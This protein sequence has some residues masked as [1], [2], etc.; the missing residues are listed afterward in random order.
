V[1]EKVRLLNW[2]S[3]YFIP[4]I[5]VW[6]CLPRAVPSHSLATQGMTGKRIGQFCPTVLSRSLIKRTQIMKNTIILG[7]ALL[8]T[9]AH[10]VIVTF[11]DL[12]PTQFYSGPG[13]GS[14]ENGLNDDPSFQSG[15]L[16]FNTN[17]DSRFGGFWSDWAYSNTTD[18]ATA[19]F[20]NQYS[21]YPGSGG[22]GS[23]NYLVVS[24]F[25]GSVGLDI[26][27]NFDLASVQLAI[28]TYS[29]GYILT[30]DNSFNQDDPKRAFGENAPVGGDLLQIRISGSENGAEV[31]SP[32]EV[33][34][35]NS[36]LGAGFG[37]SNGWIDVDLTSLA[38]ADTLQ[39]AIVNTQGGVASYFALDNFELTAIPE[40]SSALLAFA[41][42]G[43]LILPRR[44]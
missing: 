30:G 7:A 26:P 44:R 1:K 16:I 24:R 2:E 12:T 33:D 35:A 39:F 25:G 3:E 14:F 17:Y 31:A 10:A 23:A 34:L 19:G 40:P 21:A 43:F 6:C 11:E 13:G 42:I 38:S 32:I 36:S 18:T 5:A 28:T 8:C 15:P 22:N 4:E 29:A 37:I 27:A 41:S 9:H 20:A